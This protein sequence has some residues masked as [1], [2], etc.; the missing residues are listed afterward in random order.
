MICLLSVV[1]LLTNFTGRTALTVEDF[2]RYRQLDQLICN[3]EDSLICMNGGICIDLRSLYG[4]TRNRVNAQACVCEK[5]FYGP[6]CEYEDR[7]SYR[8]EARRNRK[9]AK[10]IMKKTN[11]IP[12]IIKK[13]K[14]YIKTSFVRPKLN[15]VTKK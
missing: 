11:V 12:M 13:Y 7:R 10:R 8:L 5:S 4:I 2:N 9:R 3:S 14:K 1:I 15:Q 6:H